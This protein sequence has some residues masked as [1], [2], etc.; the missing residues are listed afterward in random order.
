MALM[1]CARRAPGVRRGQAGAVGAGEQRPGPALLAR[2]GDVQAVD[3]ERE[4][5]GR[6]APA[7]AAQQ[8]VVAPAAA[9]RGAERGVVDVEHGARVVADVA[10]QAEVEDD[11]LGDRRLEQLVDLAQ[12]GDG[13]LRPGAGS[14]ASTSGPPRRWGTSSSSSAAS[15]VS[16]DSV[17]LRSQ[18]DEVAH[19]ERLA[20]GPGAP[21]RAPRRLAIR[22]GN[23]EASPRPMR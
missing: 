13:L 14:S 7:E 19:H 4:A 12:A 1:A 10:H 2:E 5:D 3:A 20:A 18:P 6:Q 17:E 16:P 11:P 22:A 8:V 23:S 9:D 21:P 15:P